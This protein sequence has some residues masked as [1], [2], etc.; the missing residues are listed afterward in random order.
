MGYDARF[1]GEFRVFPALSEYERTELHAFS[2]E[3]HEDRS[4]PGY[5]CHW[6]PNDEGTALAWNGTE[7][8]YCSAAWLLYLIETFLKPAGHVVSGRVTATGQD[9]AMSQ[10]IV[11]RSRV[12]TIE[13]CGPAPTEYALIIE[14]RHRHP[15][16]DREYDAAFDLSR[17]QFSKISPD[18]TELRSM[19]TAFAT[20]YAPL[21][22]CESGENTVV[23]EGRGITMEFWPE[24]TMILRLLASV[25]M[26]DP[27]KTFAEVTTFAIAVATHLNWIV[28]DPG[29]RIAAR[30][31]AKFRA[32]AIDM[33]SGFVMEAEYSPRRSVV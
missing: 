30:P 4:M 31:T 3:R 14:P 25:A 29:Q 28:W 32:A 26:R 16:L 21:N 24:G 22:L 5:W 17:D 2:R 11:V 13:V 20:G 9:G 33:I 27:D 8:F 6:V 7:K 1:E 15:D 12:R 23:D 19:A 10:I 18:D